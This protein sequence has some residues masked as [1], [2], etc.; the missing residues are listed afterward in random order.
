[1][2][3]TLIDATTTRHAQ[4]GDVQQGDVQQGDR[5]AAG[6]PGSGKFAAQVFA[7]I[8]ACL[9]TISNAIRREIGLLFVNVALDSPIGL[10]LTLMLNPNTNA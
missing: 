5:R 7:Y 8:S 1:M 4:Q 10:T 9:D 2:K 6:F 3:R